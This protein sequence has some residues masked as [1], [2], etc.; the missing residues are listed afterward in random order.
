MRTFRPFTSTRS[1]GVEYS[2]DAANI[3]RIYPRAAQGDILAFHYNA[4]ARSTS[5]EPVNWLALR[6][7]IG[8]K[9]YFRNERWGLL[10]WRGRNSNAPTELFIPE[11]FSAAKLGVATDSQVLADVAVGAAPRG[12]AN[13]VLL[14]KDNVDGHRLLIWD[15]V[16]NGETESSWHYTLVVSRDSGASIDI[17]LLNTLKMELDY[18]LISSNKSVV[19]FTRAMTDS[20]YAPDK[21]PQAI[22][23]TGSTY[24]VFWGNYVKFSWRGAT[25]EVDILV[26]GVKVQTG[27]AAGSLIAWNYNGM[28]QYQVCERSG[29]RCSNVLTVH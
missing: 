12:V 10:V 3:E 26:N 17:S 6:P 27:E 18:T 2:L 8:N 1:D 16:D 9:E 14:I 5:N 20:G 28:T 7:L 24:Q 19:Y 25:G 23:L 29:R 11:S 15:D 13:E 21:P 4:L 22:T